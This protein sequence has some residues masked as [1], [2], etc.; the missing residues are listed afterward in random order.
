MNSRHNT[1]LFHHDNL[2]R[3]V[4]RHRDVMCNEENR[5]S[6]EL[7]EIEKKGEEGASR[8]ID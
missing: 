1:S 7:D 6:T 8:V 4:L 3:C 5:S 2:P